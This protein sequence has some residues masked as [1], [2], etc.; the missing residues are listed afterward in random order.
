MFMA[1]CPSSVHVLPFI[2]RVKLQTGYQV[3][4]NNLISKS[5]ILRLALT[6]NLMRAYPRIQISEFPVR[7]EEMITGARDNIGGLLLIMLITGVRVR[8]C[9][10]G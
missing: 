3:C 5:D 4:L 8:L 1:F 10:H 2:L 6:K 7:S 9:G